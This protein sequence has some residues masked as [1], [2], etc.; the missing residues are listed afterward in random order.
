MTMLNPNSCYNE[1]ILKG[2]HCTEFCYGIYV[3]KITIMLYQLHKKIRISD[4]PLKYI[5]RLL[6]P[7]NI[8]KQHVAAGVY[9]NI[10]NRETI[11]A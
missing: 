11:L 1:A 4:L 3:I 9:L 10:W 7:L 8:L 5:H 6:V 2:L